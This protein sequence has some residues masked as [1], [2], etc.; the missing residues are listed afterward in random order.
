M[1]NA[2]KAGTA[3][4]AILFGGLRA[5]S[6]ARARARAAFGEAAAVL[7]ELPLILLVSWIVC[8]WLI[9]AFAVAAASGPRLAMGG[10]AFILLMA[11]ELALSSLVFGRS[12]SEHGQ[13]YL[14]LA[15]ALG[16]AGQLAFAAFPYLMLI[17]TPRTSVR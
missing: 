14:T 10:T 3:Y 9:R 6:A 1:T 12:V 2:L 8:G 4:F 13:H 17:A 5:G 15:G 16:L 7:I 11:A